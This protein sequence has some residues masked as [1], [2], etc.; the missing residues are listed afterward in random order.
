M[1]V[2]SCSDA[3]RCNG[4]RRGLSHCQL[5]PKRAASHSQRQCVCFVS[6]ALPPE[7]VDL[8]T[9][10]SSCDEVRSSDGSRQAFNSYRYII[11]TRTQVFCRCQTRLMGILLRCRRSISPRGGNPQT[12][13]RCAKYSIF[14]RAQ[15]YIVIEALRDFC[16]F[17]SFLLV[18]TT[19]LIT[20]IWFL[21]ALFTNS[22]CW[23]EVKSRHIELQIN[24]PPS[25][26][27]VCLLPHI[28]LRILLRIHYLQNSKWSISEALLPCLIRQIYFRHQSEASLITTETMGR[29]N[30]M[31][32]LI[33]HFHKLAVDQSPP[34]PQSDVLRAESPAPPP[35]PA[36]DSPPPREQLPTPPLP[37]KSTRPIRQSST[38]TP[39]IVPDT[40]EEWKM[41]LEE[42]KA[43]YIKGQY[44]QCSQRC[45]Q[46]LCAII[47]PVGFFTA[48]ISA[49]SQS[50]AW[51]VSNPS[52]PLD[53][54]LLPRSHIL[55]TRSPSQQ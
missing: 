45:K 25:Y 3:S 27:T 50:N 13:I 42:V 34:A 37:P 19:H 38:A 32:R 31:A 35:P 22:L 54:S 12:Q 10:F 33:S 24:Q 36:K 20:F 6:R 52:P 5:S 53:L 2:A 48:L 29:S 16:A 18:I 1:R 23:P 9:S 47:D 11:L 39:I 43:L 4:E 41:V 55:R 26:S 49:Q 40:P 21:S 46:V 15:T 17:F 7:S 51:L 28:F 14:A 30:K 44:K 8:S